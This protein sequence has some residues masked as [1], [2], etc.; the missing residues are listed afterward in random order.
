M[1]EFVLMTS[2]LETVYSRGYKDFYSY[3]SD[4]GGML[5]VLTILNVAV[6]SWYND[7]WLRQMLVGQGLVGQENI[8]KPGAAG[9]PDKLITIKSDL[10]NYVERGE[11]SKKDSQELGVQRVTES[12]IQESKAPKKSPTPP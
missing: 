4:I 5:E 8:H 11:L 7:Y 10:G 12:I 9:E 3:C 6:Y 1:I 2:S